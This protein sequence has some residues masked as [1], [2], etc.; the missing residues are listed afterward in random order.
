MAP[1]ELPVS[2]LSHPAKSA[3]SLDS[4]SDDERARRRSAILM[5]C[6]VMACYTGTDSMAKYL[7]PHLPLL[8]IVWARYL[9]ATLFALLLANPI[10]RPEMLR[11]ERFG[12]QLIRSLLLLVSTFLSFIS[13]R[14]LQLA[15]T[16]AISFALPLAIALAAGPILGEWIGPHRLAA[17]LVG[18]A[19]VLVVVHPWTG[20]IQPAMLLVVANVILTTG[21]NMLTRVLAQRDRSLTT[22]IYSTAA[23]AVILTPVMASVWV[24]PD[25]LPVLLAML[26]IGI[27]GACS[28][29]LLII[30]HARAPASILAP[31]VYT[32]LIWA[33]LSG[34][35]VFGDV[36][37]PATLA[38]S[39]V[40]IGSGLYLWSRE[41]AK[42]KA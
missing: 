28:H 14:Y 30:A 29:W 19:G 40:V 32:Q 9:G 23:G 21:Y 2:A 6:V 27:V 25:S 26:M 15:E 35:L 16:T 3:T 24:Q 31:F 33:I 1:K 7:A 13:V 12:L 20:T 4:A 38:G 22:L 8:Q 18:F 41:R 34:F 36:P 5:M 37:G 10:A 11:S 17:V 39:A 42:Q